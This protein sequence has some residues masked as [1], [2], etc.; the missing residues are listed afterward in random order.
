MTTT[1]EYDYL[2]RV[3]QIST[4]GDG[5][6]VSHGYPY[7]AANQRTRE[8]LADDSY[9]VY[10]YD[11]LGQVTSGKKYWSD[12]TPVAGQQFEY[13]FDD[14]GNRTQTQS[15]GRRDRGEPA[16]GGLH[17]QFPESTHATGRA[18]LRGRQGG[19]H[20]DRRVTVNG[21]TAYRKG[22]YFRQE[23]T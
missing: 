23:L 10:H 4:V 7:N 8:T 12:G 1:K 20:R 11:S 6:P 15:G 17:G 22:E 3:T 21:Q 18:G 13:A 19:G 2:N 9:W 16:Y 14:I 5:R